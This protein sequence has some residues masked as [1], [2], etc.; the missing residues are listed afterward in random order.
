[1][2]TL[3]VQLK[4]TALASAIKAVT[5]QQPKIKYDSTGKALLYFTESQNNILRQY[6]E[7][8]LN[9]KSGEVTVEIAP[10]INPIA[11]KKALPYIIGTVAGSFAVGFM[12]GK[13]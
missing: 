9:K 6:V 2:N 1:M 4:A 8:Q 10:I 3:Q 13:I 7:N 11:I 5:G 12:I